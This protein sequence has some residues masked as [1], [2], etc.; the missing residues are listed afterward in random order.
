MSAF[1]ITGIV[2]H[3]AGSYEQYL[4]MDNASRAKFRKV[5]EQNGSANSGL[6]NPDDF[7]LYKVFAVESYRGKTITTIV[8]TTDNRSEKEKIVATFGRL[9]SSKDVKLP[10]ELDDAIYEIDWRLDKKKATLSKLQAEIAEMEEIRTG[11]LTN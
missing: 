5:W 9:N 10:S 8:D 11:L 4:I 2:K 7:D 3:I 6:R 1:P